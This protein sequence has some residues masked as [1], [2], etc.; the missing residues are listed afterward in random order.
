[1]TP[2][3][4]ALT[5]A[6]DAPAAQPNGLL[7]TTT[8]GS[9]TDQYTYNLYGELASYTASHAGTPIYDVVYDSATVPR[10]N[11]G[12]VV[13]KVE[14]LDSE[15][16]THEY[17]YDEQNR[18]WRVWLDGTNV[19]EYSYDSN[20]NRLSLTTPSGT[21]SGTYDDQDR[22]LTYGDW[23]YTYTDNGE[24]LTRV[25]PTEAWSYDY[26]ALGNLLE[27][28]LPDGGLVEY[29]VDGRGRRVGKRVDG[30]LVRQWL[31]KD[32]LNPVAEL[33]GDGNLLWQ[34][35][36]GSKPNVPDYGVRGDGTLYRLVSD[37]LGSVVLVVNAN[38]AED[39]L[40]KATYSAF[41]GQTVL[42]GAADAVPF[43][44]AGG[45]YDLD[46]GLVRFGA[47]DYDAE[48]GRWT[49]KDPIRFTG[50]INQYAYVFW[51]PTF[52]P[53]EAR[54]IGKGQRELRSQRTPGNSRQTGGVN[55]KDKD[56][57]EDTQ[58]SAQPKIQRRAATAG[59]DASGLGDD[60]GE[61]SE[62]HRY[63]GDVDL[64]VAEGRD[65]Q[66][67]HARSTGRE[68][69][70]RDSSLGGCRHDRG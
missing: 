28:T 16:H 48:I 47:R 39:V 45:L 21:V 64:A 42:E 56:K 68:E 22:L 5:L 25:S 66:W 70:G 59:A 34:F 9:V 36:Y 62:G 15:S 50:G 18:L 54:K 33:D 6:Y 30:T 44:F 49:S 26:D 55:G 2:G 7:R 10:D 11:L 8:L 31:Y 67:H 14:T 57:E 61:G 35:V 17:E 63:D 23:T 27:V 24:L 58:G 32:Q 51:P 53:E 65:G 46:T 41:G 19:E 37:Q 52:C 13:Q 12:R 29:I 4:D 3:A 60:P 20:G 38:D 69:E 1:V 43:G 40:L